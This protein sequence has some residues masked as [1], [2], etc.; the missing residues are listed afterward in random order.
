MT[1]VRTSGFLDDIRRAPAR[2]AVRSRQADAR[3]IVEAAV[4][5]AA[6]LFYDFLQLTLTRLARQRCVTD[7]G[8]TA[9][10]TVVRT[11]GFLDDIIRRALAGFAARSRQADALAADQMAILEIAGRQRLV[12]LAFAGLAAGSPVADTGAAIGR[13]AVLWALRAGRGALL[14]VPDQALVTAAAVRHH[15]VDRA[16]RRLPAEACRQLGRGGGGVLDAR[17][18]MQHCGGDSDVGG[19]D[20]LAFAFDGHIL[21]DVDRDR[22]LR[23]FAHR[24]VL[25]GRRTVHVVADG[26]HTGPV[27]GNKARAVRQHFV[28][29]D[30]AEIGVGT[31]RSGPDGERG[32]IA[33]ARLLAFHR[34]LGQLQAWRVAVDVDR[35]GPD[36]DE[37]LWHLLVRL[38]QVARVAR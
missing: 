21:G 1:V 35:T 25:E 8:A 31:C 5:R 28:D 30:C 26:R 6:W 2:L 34:G 33:I 23:V 13:V 22:H 29:L 9:H 38:R 24:N 27:A 37:Q 16:L 11:S 32:V 20:H 36:I 15:L 18:A 10:V 14:A 4:V 12:G 3:P 7:T 19:V 17:V